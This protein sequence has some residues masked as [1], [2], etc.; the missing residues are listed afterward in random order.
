M[1][2]YS[3]QLVKLSDAG[4]ELAVALAEFYEASCEATQLG[5]DLNKTVPEQLPDFVTKMVKYH[6]VMSRTVTS[7]TLQVYNKHVLGPTSTLV[8]AFNQVKADLKRYRKKSLEHDDVKAGQTEGAPVSDKCQVAESVMLATKLKI[9]QQLDQ[10]HARRLVLLQQPMVALFACQSHFHQHYK[11][12]VRQFWQSTPSSSHYKCLLAEQSSRERE[13]MGVREYLSAL[14]YTNGDDQGGPFSG[15]LQYPF[16]DSGFTED[17]RKDSAWK[18]IAAVTPEK[19]VRRLDGK[20]FSET[21]HMLR[22]DQQQAG[23][24]SISS[25]SSSS[26]YRF[27]HQKH[28]SIAS[29]SSSTARADWGIGLQPQSES[30]PPLPIPNGTAFEW[31]TNTSSGGGGG[32]SGGSSGGGSGGSSGGGSGGG[33][34]GGGGG[35]DS[36]GSSGGGGGGSSG[37]GGGGGSSDGSRSQ[38]KREKRVSQVLNNTLL[39]V[40]APDADGWVIGR[41]NHVRAE[42]V[43]VD[44]IDHESGW[45]VGKI[46]KWAPSAV[47]DLGLYSF[48]LVSSTLC[49]WTPTARSEESV[50]DSTG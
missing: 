2:N 34:G 6:Q 18:A 16:Y 7:A 20:N 31:N 29:S 35:G 49:I 8:G 9:T 28:P 19:E 14:S 45:V 1:A 42:T 48:C 36:S 21:H 24:S 10:L 26:D 40:E 11:A 32:G 13:H 50:R 37:S 27:Q 4:G 5:G 23:A 12:G 47:I 17:E 39:P 46:G 15:A 43:Q 33:G 3:E 30:R 41:I 22:W 44:P 38:P 25:S